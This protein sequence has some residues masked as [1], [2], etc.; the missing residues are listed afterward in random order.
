MRREKGMRPYGRKCRDDWKGMD[1]SGFYVQ[2]N[3]TLLLT[4]LKCYL[5]IVNSS[6]FFG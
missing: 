3:C 5:K 4:I 6:P 1:V 2:I